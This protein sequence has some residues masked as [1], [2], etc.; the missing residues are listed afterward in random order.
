MK[1]DGRCK[2]YYS[3]DRFSF[4]NLID[5]IVIPEG[6]PTEEMVKAVLPIREAIS[7]MMPKSL[8]RFRSCDDR[9]IDAFEKDAIYA[10][11]ADSFND[12]YD[13]LL[14]YD[15]EGIRQY[16][17]YVMSMEGLEKLKTFFFRRAV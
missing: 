8:F 7:E 5:S 13:M 16:V 17:D 12:P 3:M 15:M 14:R 10:V 11:T 2:N 1:A 6:T 9:H 4:G